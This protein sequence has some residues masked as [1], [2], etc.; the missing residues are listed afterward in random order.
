MSRVVA[1]D[2]ALTEE[3]QRLFATARLR[4]ERAGEAARLAGRLADPSRANRYRA[5]ADRTGVPWFVV[6]VVHALEASLDFSRHLHNGDPLTGRT[7]QVP[8]GRPLTGAPPFAWEDSAVDA[9]TLAGLPV[10]RDWSAA[11]VA[12][13]LERYNGFGYHRRTPPVPSPYLW[14]FTTAYASGKY[15]ADHVWSDTATSKQCGAMALIRVLCDAGVIALADG[16]A[17]RAPIAPAAAGG[18]VAAARE[19]L[20]AGAAATAAVRSSQALEPTA[21]ARQDRGGVLLLAATA[22]QGSRL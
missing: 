19:G 8:K 6:G 12:Y 20:G 5:V 15:V 11:G 16:P 10:W 9:L 1:F 2:A 17:R 3:Y 4:P 21:A 7:V 13:V 14:S 18:H 22:V